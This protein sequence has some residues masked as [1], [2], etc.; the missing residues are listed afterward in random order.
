MRMNKQVY[1]APIA[2]SRGVAL[3]IMRFNNDRAGVFAVSKKYAQGLCLSLG[4]LRYD[5]SHKSG[6]GYWQ[7]YHGN[8]CP[9]AHC[10]YIG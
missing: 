10:W 8:S 9:E 7:H 6:T 2:I 5:N 3:T 4:G 1:V